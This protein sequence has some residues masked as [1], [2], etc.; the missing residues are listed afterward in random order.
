MDAAVLGSDL[1]A[2]LANSVIGWSASG[3]FEND[4]EILAAERYA[5]ED[6]LSK[7]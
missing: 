3:S 7:A 4:V 5:S 6:W 2:R 1:A